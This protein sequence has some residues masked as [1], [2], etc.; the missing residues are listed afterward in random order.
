[1]RLVELRIENFR[2]FSD[3]TIDL[4]G[5]SCLVGPNGSGKSTVLRSLNVLFRNPTGTSSISELGAE[6]FHDRDTSRPVRITATFAD[7]RD[8]AY[9]DLKAYVRQGR[10]AVSAVATWDAA[11]QKAIV[12]QHGSRLVMN[13]FS[14]F[15]EEE[16]NGANVAALTKVYADT[17]KR[18]PELPAAKTKAEMTKALRDY[19]ESHPELCEF[20]ESPDEFYGWTRGKN[21]LS[22]HVQ[23]VYVPAV[24]DAA[25]EQLEGRNTALGILLQRTIRAKIRFDEEIERLRSEFGDKYQAM[26]RG[27]E[28]VL[29]GVSESI[30]RRLKEWAHPG[31]EL[32]LEWSYERDKSVVVSDPSACV[33]LAEGGFM[34]SVVNMG[35]G[36]QRA[37]IVS[38]LQELAETGEEEQPTLILGIEEPELYQHPPQARH[39]SEVLERLAD[40]NCQVLVTTHSP[41][42]VSGKGFEDVR[43]VRRLHD[44][45]TR[46]SW[47]TGSQ[48]SDMLAT[49]LG[50]ARA[51]PSS[52]MARVEQILQPSQ[53]ELFFCNVPV[54]VEGVEDI[55]VIATCLRLT[56]CWWRFRELGCHFVQAG[57]KNSMSRLAAITRCLKVP[58]FIVFDGDSD[59]KPEQT[60]ANERDNARLLSLCGCGEATP[61]PGEDFWASDLVMWKTQIQPAVVA[62]VGQ[63]AWADAQETARS[64][65]GLG[66]VQQK[67]GLLIAATLEELWS[68]GHTSPRLERL[69]RTILKHAEESQ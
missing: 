37:F 12:R 61:M 17:R 16:K 66:G 51:S 13:E 11:T 55:A 25:T 36:L 47:A 22:R 59:A 67:N 9:Q 43:M 21:L 24:K 19:E 3:Q 42:F 54:I 39:L 33:R 5:Y 58:A 28:D 4:G 38:L 49:A 53:N 31:V 69:C 52:V 2:S 44:G 32:K 65:H 35:H 15:F 68:G 64:K 50:E 20:V 45:G 57:G 48:I 1:M 40:R 63:V 23:W 6:D 10:L 62:D 26:I 27:H 41:L 7:L 18:T 8:L 46:V 34:G 56:D 30:E 60:K 14:G 29:S